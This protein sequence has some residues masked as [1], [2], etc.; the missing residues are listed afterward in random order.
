M[1]RTSLR[2]QPSPFALARPAPVVFDSLFTGG[3]LP[4]FGGSDDDL[5][6]AVGIAFSVLTAGSCPGVRLHTATTETGTLV[7]ELYADA[8]GTLLASASG[9]GNPGAGDYDILFAAPV[10]L[11]TST[12]YVASVWHPEGRYSFTLNYW[13]FGPFTSASG[14]LFTAEGGAYGPGRYAYGAGPAH[15]AN[16]TG[17][18]YGV[19]PLFTAP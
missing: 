13:N 9:P 17:S 1:A 6:L 16:N 18:W 5:P 14:A 8:G 15:P 2:W 10:A 7:G 11:S 12:I 3:T 4:T 19:E